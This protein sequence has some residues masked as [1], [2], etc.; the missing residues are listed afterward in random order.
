M[1]YLTFNS[2]IAVHYSIGMLTVALVSAGVIIC[3]KR[4]EHIA[5]ATDGVHIDG[6]VSHIVVGSDNGA[7]ICACHTTDMLTR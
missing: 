1:I 4:D 6:V 2:P 5:I 7:C 3:R